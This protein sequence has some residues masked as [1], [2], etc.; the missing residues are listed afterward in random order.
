MLLFSKK[1]LARLNSFDYDDLMRSPGTF[2]EKKMNCLHGLQ[3]TLSVEKNT[4][5][6]ALKLRIYTNI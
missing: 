1:S 4:F 3:C 6:K 2:N 5:S